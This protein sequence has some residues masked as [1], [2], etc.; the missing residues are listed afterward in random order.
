MFRHYSGGDPKC[1]CCEEP[2]LVF[3]VIDHIEGGGN[4]HRKQTRTR[5]GYSFYLWLIREGFPEGFRV[6]CH[7]C[8]MATGTLG[9]CPH[10]G[11]KC[12]ETAATKI[13]KALS[14]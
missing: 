14:K 12:C 3:L 1:A 4:E 5:G 6:L 8:N 13:T 10:K 9:Y 2:N 11:P 7:N